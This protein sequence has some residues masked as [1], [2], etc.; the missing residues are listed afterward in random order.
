MQVTGA[1]LEVRVAGG[2]WQPVELEVTSAD[3]SGPGEQPSSIFPEGRAFVTAFR[4][5]FGELPD[6]RAALAYDAAM[7]I[8]R[9]VISKG[10]D[11]HKVRDYVAA[12]GTPG[13]AYRGV[14]GLIAFNEKHDVVRKSVVIATVGRQ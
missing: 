3:A 9:A 2:D 11:R 8:G 6:Q 4:A 5:K 14:T 10:A 12:I 13:P 7:I 1:T